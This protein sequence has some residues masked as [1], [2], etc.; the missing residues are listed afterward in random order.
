MKR[1]G[2]GDLVAG[3][4]KDTIRVQKTAPNLPHLDMRNYC[5]QMQLNSKFIY[6]F[7]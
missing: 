2:L 5:V 6:L 4:M 7:I 1:L 3:R